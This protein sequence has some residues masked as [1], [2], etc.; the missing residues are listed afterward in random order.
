MRSTTWALRM[1]AGLAAVVLAAACGSSSDADGQQPGG[2][3]DAEPAAGE[4]TAPSGNPIGCLDDYQEGV[5]YFPDKVSAEHAGGWDV[6]YEDHY[7]VL[8]TTVTAAGGHAGASDRV[9]DSTYV[10]L[11]CGAPEPELTGDLAGATVVEIPS[12]TFV[13]G[14]SVLYASVE[15]LGIADTL[16]GSAEPFIGDVEAPYLPEVAQRIQSGAVAEIGYEVNY[17]LLAETDP[18]FYT[19]YAGDDAMFGQIDQLGIPIVFYFPYT[20]TPLG[21]A[22]QV[23]FLSLFFN[24][25]AAANEIFDPIEQRYVELREQVA[26]V[27][28]R[29]SVLIGVVGDG[30]DVTT[31]ENQRFEPQLVREA[32]G[33]PV[34]DLDGGG[35]ATV[36]LEQFLDDGADADVWLDL[37]FFPSHETAADY[38][39][40]DPRL[41][42]LGP[43]S[44]GGTYHR[45][46]P[47][48]SDY[49][50]SGAVDVDLMLADMVSVLHPDVLPGHDLAFLAHVPS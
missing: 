41:A 21:A 29:P 20:E 30:G 32:G 28:S 13:D 9:I 40:A 44:N 38:V 46:G 24:L 22:E 7:K 36:S 34:P 12:E 47:R 16:V 31:R 10:L 8:T 25:E 18:D 42:T 4:A 48:G 3:S 49:F 26:D 39:A 37:T 43:L 2:T 11:Q 35:I 50:L 6:R 33:E 5:D 15:K 14:G 17:E 19:N 27:A 45:V 23:K 1:G